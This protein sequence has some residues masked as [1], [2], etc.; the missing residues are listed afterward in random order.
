MFKYLYKNKLRYEKGQLAPFFIAILVILIIMA[1]V[2]VNLGKVGLV[3]TDTSNAADA[4]ALAGGSIMA[5]VF[6][7]QALMNGEMIVSYEFFMASLAVAITLIILSAKLAAAACKVNVCPPLIDCC[8]SVGCKGA[9]I[10]VQVGLISAMVATG[11]FHVA[12]IFNYLKMQQEA[13]KGRTAA[14]ELAYRYAFYNSGIGG[15]LIEDSPP[16][17]GMRGDKNN[18]QDTFNDFVKSNISDAS[19]IDY[20]WKDGQDRKH[21]VH[22]EVS[23]D[24]VEHYSLQ[25]TIL[26]LLGV[27][28]LFYAAFYVSMDELLPACWECPC[29]APVAAAA[30]GW[31]ALFSLAALAGLAPSPLPFD[32]NLFSMILFPICWVEDI[33]HDRRFTVRTKQD[34]GPYDYG[35]WK[36]EYPTRESFSIVSFE[37]KGKIYEPVPSFDPSII[38]TD[39]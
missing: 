31:I 35:L 27:L 36:M 29:S 26:P 17:E 10:D 5:S 28:A 4:G 13:D 23:T 11:L 22:V 32:A 18:Y 1:M 33:K 3:K 12:Q 21:L 16:E 8:L 20:G 24:D 7:T 39:R 19:F 37:G 15:K 38:E 14:I 25:F 2:T 9:A 30:V 6:N 34:H